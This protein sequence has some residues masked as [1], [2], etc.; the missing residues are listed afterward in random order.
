MDYINL[1]KYLK[2]WYNADDKAVIGFGGSYGAMLATWIR[3]KHP[4]V[5]QGV[6]ASSAPILYFTNS[7]TSY[8]WSFAAQASID[9]RDAGPNCYTGIKSGFNNLTSSST[10]PMYRKY[11]SEVFNTCDQVETEEDV[12]GL[13]KML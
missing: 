4:H 6:L 11:I 2:T 3:M 5:F 13:I 12:K 1:V 7:S 10:I 9:F 8:E